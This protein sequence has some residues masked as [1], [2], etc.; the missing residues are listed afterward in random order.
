MPRY[1]NVLAGLVVL[2]LAF[3]TG[4]EAVVCGAN[5]YL[6]MN[7]LW[8]SAGVKNAAICTGCPTS[9]TAPAG[10]IGGYG[11]S[12]APRYAAAVA[13]GVARTAIDN[14]LLTWCNVPAGYWL[15]TAAVQHLGT[16]AVPG[17]VTACVDA[18]KTTSGGTVISGATLVE[19]VAQCYTASKCTANQYLEM[20]GAGGDANAAKCTDCPTSMTAPATP[21]LTNVQALVV[22]DGI[23]RSAVDNSLVT[24]CNVPAG[25]YLSTAVVQATGT[26]ASPGAVTACTANKDG[27][28]GATTGIEQIIAAATAIQF[29][30]S[31]CIQKST[32]AADQYL[33]NDGGW[34]V[35]ASAAAASAAN[36]LSAAKSALTFATSTVSISTEVITVT[37]AFKDNQQL[38]YNSNGGSAITELTDGQVVY[39]HTVSGTA[40]FKLSATY[41]GSV[42]A[43]SGT[44]NSAQTLTPTYVTPVAA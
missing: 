44:G 23:A 27:Y 29:P 11:D 26:T 10:V 19:T 21:A 17:A 33:K 14:T 4:V 5:Q 3:A 9:M 38:T 42:L 34:V 32:C 2:V 12:T 18:L 16:T 40:S 22:K 35:K 30:V 43:L 13:A 6:E 39:A 28:R 41:G 36:K 25:F 31:H 24:W 15:S 7:G 37:H 1:N 20:D 8:T